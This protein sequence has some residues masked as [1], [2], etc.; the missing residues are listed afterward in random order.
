[1]NLSLLDLQGEVLIVS[2]FTLY[3]NCRKGRRPSFT[4]AA[5][6]EFAEAMYKKFV[7]TFKGTGVKVEKGQ[8]GAMMDVALINWGPVTMMLESECKEER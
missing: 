4:D 1:M 5:V 2:Q 3:A 8:F 6:P 7:Q